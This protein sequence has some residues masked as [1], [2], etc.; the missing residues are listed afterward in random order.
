MSFAYG[1]LL[2]SRTT[3]DKESQTI[4]ACDRQTDRRTDGQT[5]GH[6]TCRASLASRG[7]NAWEL[8]W[9]SSIEREQV[10][11]SFVSRRQQRSLKM[12]RVSLRRQSSCWRTDCRAPALDASYTAA[13][14]SND[15]LSLPSLY[16]VHYIRQAITETGRPPRRFFPVKIPTRYSPTTAQ[17]VR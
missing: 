13:N 1:L 9:W 4:P 3:A 10:E 12:Y 11:W 7:K 14:R 8:T 6:S 17:H 5:P 2:H 15:A 16:T